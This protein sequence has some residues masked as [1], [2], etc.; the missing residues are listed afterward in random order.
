MAIQSWTIGNML[1]MSRALLLGGGTYVTVVK[2][3][4]NE[5]LMVLDI[6]DVTQVV[7][8]IYLKKDGIKIVTKL[9][10]LG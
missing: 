10:S 4:G 6:S 3:I 2:I 7:K 1:V 9:L 5:A 8:T